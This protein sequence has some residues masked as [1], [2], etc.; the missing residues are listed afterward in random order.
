MWLCY[1]QKGRSCSWLKNKL[2]TID[3]DR[4]EMGLRVCAC[5]KIRCSQV[6][7]AAPGTIELH[8]A[9]ILPLDARLMLVMTYAIHRTSLGASYVIC[10][11]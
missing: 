11:Q 2:E 6:A 10:E 1:E 7:S 4:N 5:E 8:Q 3:W 9:H